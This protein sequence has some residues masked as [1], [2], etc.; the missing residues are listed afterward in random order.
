MGLENNSGTDEPSIQ[1]TSIKRSDFYRRA[2]NSIL[3]LLLTGI[4]CVTL[5][6]GRREQVPTRTP[7]TQFDIPGPSSNEVLAGYYSFPLTGYFS[8]SLSD[9]RLILPSTPRKSEKNE[10]V[11]GGIGLS[12]Y[13]EYTLLDDVLLGHSFPIYQ[14]MPPLPEPAGIR[15]VHRFNILAG[16]LQIDGRIGEPRYIDPMV[17]NTRI[18]QLFEVDNPSSFVSYSIIQQIYNPGGQYRLEASWA[19]R[20][21]ARVAAVNWNGVP[22]STAIITQ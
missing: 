20:D 8:D 9:Y 19:I 7:G 12:G 1:T 4:G 13:L 21:N 16:T 15:V 11:L 5:P 14:V 6:E 22:Q 18:M 10:L 2:C 3:A 17:R